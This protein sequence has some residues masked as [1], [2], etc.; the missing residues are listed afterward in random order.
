MG[1]VKAPKTAGASVAGGRET[2][3]VLAERHALEQGGE[4]C[5]RGRDRLNMI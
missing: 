1:I 3:E 2:R 5:E 4:T